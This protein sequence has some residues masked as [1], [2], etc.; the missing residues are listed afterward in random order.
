MI[1]LPW[2]GDR[3]E[4]LAYM[5]RLIDKFPDEVC[6]F[7]CGDGTE[8]ANAIAD[9]WGAEPH[10]IIV[11]HDIWP[12]PEQWLAL[13]L[14]T[15]PLTVFPYTFNKDAPPHWTEGTSVATHGGQLKVG[16][17]WADGSGIGLIKI[18]AEGAR[19]IDL[20]GPMATPGGVVHGLYPNDQLW[21]TRH[22]GNLDGVLSLLAQAAG[23][24]FAV[25]WPLVKHKNLL[26]PEWENTGVWPLPP[27]W[28][29]EL[30]V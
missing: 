2:R 9:L 27:H 20:D 15:H 14:S 18:T 5:H 3:S 4:W 13:L 28:T 1:L 19:R 26:V 16:D 7:E 17:P 22:W 23:I 29:R 12:T 8:Y 21:R 10:L 30:V 24:R 11:E 6:E 25:L